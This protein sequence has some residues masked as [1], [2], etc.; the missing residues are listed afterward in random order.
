MISIKPIHNDG[1]LSQALERID[2]LWGATVGSP[3][4]D[5]LDILTLLVERYEDAN[6][7]MPPSD[8]V[9][10][11]KFMMEQKGLTQKDM[12]QYLGSPSKAS[13]VLNRKRPLSINMVKRLHT[14]LSIPYDCLLA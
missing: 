5:E 4:G 1:D 11:I 14:G 9:A 12:V 13:E 8:P 10:A 2:A 6:Y 3:K 7:P